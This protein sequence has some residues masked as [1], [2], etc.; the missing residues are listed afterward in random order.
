[1]VILGI[2]LLYVKVRNW[3]CSKRKR[4]LCFPHII[5]FN[6][7]RAPAQRQIGE[8]AL[9][10]T[11]SRSHQ[12][13]R[14]VSVPLI[15]YAPHWYY[16]MSIDNT[17]SLELTENC[18]VLTCICN[19]VIMHSCVDYKTLLAI[20]MQRYGGK[21]G[22]GTSASKEWRPEGLGTSRANACVIYKAS[23]WHGG[24]L[25]TSYWQWM[26]TIFTSMEHS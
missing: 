19:L 24:I 1:M 20:P 8:T 13:L 5:W 17:F 7:F 26:H 4:C 21:K 16:I 10:E 22:P 15:L 11:S 6:C 2:F 23:F 18:K 14:L 3:T 25:K 9:N 12:I